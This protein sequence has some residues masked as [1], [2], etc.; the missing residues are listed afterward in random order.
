VNAFSPAPV[1]I[2]AATESSAPS[3][4]SACPKRR[5]SSAVNAFICFGR[6]SVT[7]ATPALISVRRISS[8]PAP[9][10]IEFR[11]ILPES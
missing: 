9:V 11:S 6:F 7:V 10:I 1:M 4:A 3:A 8:M 5:R 2:T